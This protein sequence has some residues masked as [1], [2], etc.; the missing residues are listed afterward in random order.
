MASVYFFVKFQNGFSDYSY[1][2]D[3]RFKD[4]IGNQGLKEKLMDM[5]E[6]NRTGHSLM[7]V[8][9]EGAGALP[10]A[11]ALIQYISCPHRIPHVDSCGE[12]PTCKKIS[13]SQHPDLHFVFPVNLNSKA[14]SSA[15]AVSDTFIRQW[16]E[17]VAENPYFTERDLSQ[18]LEIEEKVSVINV[19]EAKE[20]LSKLSL[21]AFEGENKYMLIWLPEKMNAEAANRLLKIVE[22]PAPGTFFIFVSHSPEKVLQTIRSRSLMIRVQPIPA[23]DIALRL[24]AEKGLSQE[25]S[26][27]Y[28]RSAGGSYGR[29]L[30]HFRDHN[31]GSAMLPM[32]E[33][34]LRSVVAKDLPS[35]L[36]E[37]DKIV[38]LGR[39]KEKE[40]IIYTEDLLRKILMTR[41]G[42]PQISMTT[43]AEKNVVEEFAKVLPDSFFEKAVN[44]LEEAGKA[45]EN[46]VNAKMVFC[47]LVN[48]L[49]SI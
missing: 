4:T 5:V 19:A 37:N 12:C 35:L 6:S 30:E 11:L 17:L 38:E 1:F 10:L 39:V 18:K 45:L 16:R 20:I 22:E 13:A 36:T 44:A 29:V 46:N 7:F 2:C 3:M 15:K 21:K 32:A 43:P 31:R 26:L 47:H 9:E 24:S 40:F 34:M 27:T 49:Y 8:E 23:D 48:I 14:S 25:E 42:V 28:A 41:R 33:T